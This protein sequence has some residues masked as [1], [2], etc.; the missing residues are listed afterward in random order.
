MSKID[1][2]ELAKVVRK[3]EMQYSNA[4]DRWKNLKQWIE[5][6]DY[7]T[8]R[9]AE[10]ELKVW[11]KTLWETIQNSGNFEIIRRQH[12]WHCSVMVKRKDLLPLLNESELYKR[13]KR[14]Q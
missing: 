14:G 7:L 1:T 2:K 6:N 4:T 5:E 3:I 8:L 13:K 9:E 10:K 12:G 11:R